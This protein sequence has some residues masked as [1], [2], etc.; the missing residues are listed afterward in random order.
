M[1]GVSG[2]FF[3][4]GRCRGCCT[5]DGGKERDIARDL[6]DLIAGAFAVFA[7]DM[8]EGMTGGSDVE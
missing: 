8:V 3:R 2:E 1:S 4:V 5:S 7:G 6:A